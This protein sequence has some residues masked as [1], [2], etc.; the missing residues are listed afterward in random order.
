MTPW[1]PTVQAEAR[2]LLKMPA[3]RSIAF[4][5]IEIA[6]P[7]VAKVSEIVIELK[8]VLE[9]KSFVFL[10][11][12]VGKTRS[13]PG[14]G[15]TFPSQLA[16][17]VQLLLVPAPVQVSVASNSRSSSC[18]SRGLKVTRPRCL[19][20]VWSDSRCPAKS[21]RIPPHENGMAA[22]FWTGLAGSTVRT[23]EDE[24]KQ[25]PRDAFYNSKCVQLPRTFDRMN[26]FWLPRAQQFDDLPFKAR[27]ILG[28]DL[29]YL[30]VVDQVIAMDQ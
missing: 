2:A 26:L 4:P 28:D 17:L 30:G 3:L 25:I 27:Q 12:P 24:V 9:V 16:G 1:N 15:A 21:G 14:L 23:A 5:P 8:V 11:V 20:T 19:E 18:S 13:S 6:A 7:A 10:G 22:R 29:P